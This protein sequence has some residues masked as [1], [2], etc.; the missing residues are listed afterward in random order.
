MF[1]FDNFLSL[2][3]SKGNIHFAKLFSL[4]NVVG[5][6]DGSKYCLGKT[7]AAHFSFIN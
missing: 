1:N 5:G 4:Y 3:N 7:Y 6:A 2:G